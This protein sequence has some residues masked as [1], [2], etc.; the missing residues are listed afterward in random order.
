MVKRIGCVL[1]LFFLVN[2]ELSAQNL[3]SRKNRD[4]FPSSL[5][6]HMGGWH[7][8]PGFTYMF[9]SFFYFPFNDGEIYNAGKGK[10]GI[11][12]EAGR[13]RILEYATFFKY[14]DYGI[15][16]KS[17]RGLDGSGGSFGDHFIS[18][19]FN[20]NHAWTLSD[21]SY[22]QNSV[23]INLDYPFIRNALA[24]PAKPVVQLHYKLGFGFKIGKNTLAIPAVETAIL[25]AW[26]WEKGRS[27]L[28]YGSSRYRPLIVS[29]RFLFFRKIK[30]K[31]CIKVPAP[32]LP[33]GYK[34]PTDMEE[35]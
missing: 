10:F 7:F 1:L 22:L 2:G 12:L 34:I 19:F 27:T 21:V 9:P 20:L 23:G 30:E 31:H 6:Y 5:Q 29:V 4:V 15:A 35:Q 13:Y 14:L 18:G 26:P 33:D 25:N 3:Y 32:D 28:G 24:A 17:L 11:Y 16:Y 8:A